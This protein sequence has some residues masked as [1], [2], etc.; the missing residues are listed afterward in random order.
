MKKTLLYLSILAGS[1]SIYA[2]TGEQCA[3]YI[4]RIGDEGGVTYDGSNAAIFTANQAVTTTLD[5]LEFSTAGKIFPYA[6]ILLR[7]ITATDSSAPDEDLV[8]CLQEFDDRVNTL[9][10]YV[11]EGESSI[12]IKR[13]R[14]DIYF[15]INDQNNHAVHK[16]AYEEYDI[17]SED[18]AG[19]ISYFIDPEE[20]RSADKYDTIKNDTLLYLL[21][22]EY[23]LLLII[24][25]LTHIVPIKGITVGV[26]SLQTSLLIT[27]QVTLG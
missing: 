4:D 9:E 7:Q 26:H 6:S 13:V 11:L 1:S 14:G 27:S 10:D 12:D 17:I 16:D 2:D 18:L 25:S 23:L 20:Q 24:W 5:L 3:S 15:E 8:S 22:T 19:I 21:S